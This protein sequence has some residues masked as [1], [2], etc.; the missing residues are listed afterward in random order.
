[1]FITV[2]HNTTIVCRRNQESI[3]RAKICVPA[4][5]KAERRVVKACPQTNTKASQPTAK[6]G[7]CNRIQP[8]LRGSLS[9]MQMRFKSRRPVEWFDH[10]A[11]FPR[12]GRFCDFRPF[13]K[14]IER[15][16]MQFKIN[17]FNCNTIIFILL[18]RSHS[19]LACYCVMGVRVFAP[20]HAN[21]KWTYGSTE[22]VHCTCQLSSMYVSKHSPHTH[23]N[24]HAPPHTHTHTIGL[25]YVPPHSDRSQQYAG[26]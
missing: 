10:T 9:I 8:K 25:I 17:R 12:F 1:M 13:R 15:V 20:L 6:K 2:Y 14:Q 21:L 18:T 23:I 22:A 19:V 11:P 26:R 16:V 7:N 4:V 5:P 3:R 24:T